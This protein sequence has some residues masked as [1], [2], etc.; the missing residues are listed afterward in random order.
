MITKSLR[1]RN[2]FS[3]IEEIV[4]VNYNPRERTM[5]IFS[6]QE[7]SINQ[8]IQEVKKKSFE[9][10]KVSQGL[11]VPNERTSR[12]TRP[13]TK[14]ERSQSDKG[15]FVLTKDEIE[16]LNFNQNEK[17][18]L[19]PFFYPNQIG[20][21][22]ADPE[23]IYN[24]IYMDQLGVQ[25]IIRSPEKFPNIRKHLLSFSKRITSDH[26]PYGLHRPRKK[27]IFTNPNKILIA[28]KSKTPHA[29]I[30]RHSAFV[31][32][33]VIIID[34]PHEINSEYLL[35]LLNSNII[36]YWFRTQKTLGDILQID[37]EVIRRL[38]IPIPSKRVQKIISDIVD[39]I[40]QLSQKENP[41]S[42]YLEKKEELPDKLKT[43]WKELNVNVY[44]LFNLK[45]ED[46]LHIEATLFGS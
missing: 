12:K 37:I 27:Q 36:H 5:S 28:R 13:L 16:K 33:G 8:S 6:K 18:F 15:I 9:E 14:Q 30:T 7:E 38:P 1:R 19:Q 2:G 34:P 20:A 46:I 31:N 40:I 25:R 39:E 22:W 32:Q 45:K 43:K 10:V 23:P 4:T 29:A 21:F 3:S 44:R 24:I 17:R 26:K 35:G 11:I 41:I 42:Y